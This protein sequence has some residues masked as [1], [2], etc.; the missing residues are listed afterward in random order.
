[1]QSER[2]AHSSPG[3]KPQ[4][5]ARMDLK[6]NGVTGIRMVIGDIVLTFSQRHKNPLQSCGKTQYAHRAASVIIRLD[7]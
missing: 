1:M 4:G 6:Q 7:T 5:Q 3:L 2:C